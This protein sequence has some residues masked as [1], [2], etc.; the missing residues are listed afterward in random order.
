MSPDVSQANLVPGTTG[1]LLRLSSIVIQYCP[2]PK[3][4]PI[5]TRLF[6]L[7]SPRPSEP[8]QLMWWLP[9][10]KVSGNTGFMAS[11]T[12]SSIEPSRSSSRSQKGTRTSLLSILEAAHRFVLSKEGSPWIHREY[13]K[14][15]FSDDS[16]A[17]RMGLSPLEGL[18][19][20]TCSGGVDPR[21]VP[22]PCVALPSNKSQQG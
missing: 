2:R 18:P 7:Q 9:K 13:W 21:L 12:R 22:G 17:S 8:M 16:D 10:K 3:T 14:L 11:A 20:A 19:G 15:Y 5:M 1:R 6:M 4:L